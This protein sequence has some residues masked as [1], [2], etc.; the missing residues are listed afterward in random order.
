[1]S[2]NIGAEFTL[3][4][5]DDFAVC[6]SSCAKSLLWVIVVRERSGSNFRCHA[7]PCTGEALVARVIL[8][9]SKKQMPQDLA[10]ASTQFD[11]H[12]GNR[13]P[14]TSMGGLYDATTL[15]VPL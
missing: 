10:T 5:F 6:V 14:V 3:W 7:K 12:T 4:G 11:A 2:D 13:T 9:F 15:C 1:M 8:R